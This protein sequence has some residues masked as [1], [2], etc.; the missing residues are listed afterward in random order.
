MY[1]PKLIYKIIN[2][3]IPIYKLSAGIPCESHVR[4]TVFD[5]EGSTISGLIVT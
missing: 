2:T 4:Q 5:E 1:L 3:T